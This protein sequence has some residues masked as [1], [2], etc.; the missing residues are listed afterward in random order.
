[1]VCPKC[2]YA[3]KESDTAPGWQ[4]PSCGIAIDKYRAGHETDPTLKSQWDV[5]RPQLPLGRRLGMATLDLAMAALFFWCWIAPGAWHPTLATELGT[6]MLME[7]FVIHSSMFLVIGADA[8]LGT[9]LTTGFLVMLFYVPIAGAFAWW[10][11]GWWPVLA[12]AWLLA[13]RV[14]AML[15]GQGPDAFE[16]RR[17]RYYWA[18]GAG[19]YIVMIFAALLLPIPQL[20]FANP[21]AYVWSG[22]ILRP[23]HEIIAWGF[24]YFAGQAVMKILERPEWIAATE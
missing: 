3:R 21:G 14:L 12:F 20:G 13:S 6:V 16:A 10:Q 5:L 24:L 8:P 15:A 2:G 11:G 18:N 1:M 23:P 17:G 9:R 22:R 19:L 4:C 7:F